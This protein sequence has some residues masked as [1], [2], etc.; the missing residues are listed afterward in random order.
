MVPILANT[1]PSKAGRCGQFVRLR[2]NGKTL[3]VFNAVQAMCWSPGGH[4][5][6]ILLGWSFTLFALQGLQGRPLV[7]HGLKSRLHHNLRSCDHT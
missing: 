7:M 5:E 4:L 3:R 6:G 2:C 1:S